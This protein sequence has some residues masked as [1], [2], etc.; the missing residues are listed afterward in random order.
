MGFAVPS[1]GVSGC[2][3]G[4]SVAEHGVY[5]LWIWGEGCPLWEKELFCLQVAVYG[6]QGRSPVMGR[7]ALR[8][9]GLQGSAP[10]CR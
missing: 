1:M 6:T 8:E 5:G 9:G 10:G 4:T 3:Y 2:G 7:F